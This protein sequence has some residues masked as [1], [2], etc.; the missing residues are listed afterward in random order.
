[1]RPEA[2]DALD[3]LLSATPSPGAWA[4]GAKGLETLAALERSRQALREASNELRGVTA[5]RAHA[6]F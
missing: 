4:G 1:M 2:L 3:L 6:G 5:G